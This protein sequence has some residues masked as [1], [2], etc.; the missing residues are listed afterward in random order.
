MQAQKQTQFEK[1]SIVVFIFY[2][3]TDVLINVVFQRSNLQSLV[4]F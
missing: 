4:V 2:F 3:L 1:R